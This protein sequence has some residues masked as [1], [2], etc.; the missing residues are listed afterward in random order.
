MANLK[1]FDVDGVLQRFDPTAMVA[2]TAAAQAAANAAVQEYHELYASTHQAGTD[3]WEDWD[4]SAIVP[5]GAR[6]AQVLC[7]N[8]VKQVL[9]ARKDGSAVERKY[10]TP[11]EAP[12]MLTC[13][14]VAGTIEILAAA[15]ATAFFQIVGCWI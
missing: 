5:A 7:F 11:A 15:H 8:A 10:N 2:A 3:T 9:G 14:I 12:L 4:I 1:I 13:E 6:Y